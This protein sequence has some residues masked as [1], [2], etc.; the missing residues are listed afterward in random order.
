MTTS[1]DDPVVSSDDMLFIFDDHTL[2][3]GRTSAVV[4]RRRQ[5]LDSGNCTS[6]EGASSIYVTE[7]DPDTSQLIFNESS[8]EGD[9]ETDSDSRST[10]RNGKKQKTMPRQKGKRKIIIPEASGS[11]RSMPSKTSNQQKQRSRMITRGNKDPGIDCDHQIVFTDSEI[12][13]NLK[14]RKNKDCKSGIKGSSLTK[15]RGLSSHKSQKGTS[16]AD[17]LS[18]DEKDEISAQKE[19]VAALGRSTR[20]KANFHD[21]AHFASDR[22]EL[23]VD[24]QQD[25]NKFTKTLSKVGL[26]NAAPSRRGKEREASQAGIKNRVKSVTVKSR[27]NGKHD[28]SIPAQH[29]SPQKRQLVPGMCKKR[30]HDQ[31]SERKLQKPFFEPRITRAMRKL[32]QEENKAAST[33]MKDSQLE[34]TLSDSGGTLHKTVSDYAEIT[35][36]LLLDSSLFSFGDSSDIVDGEKSTDKGQ[37][38]DGEPITIE[39]EYI[40]VLTI[41]LWLMLQSHVSPSIPGPPGLSWANCINIKEMGGI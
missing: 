4:A 31:L 15:S 27:A 28:P 29:V 33:K 21:I 18:Q 11:A 1:R 22:Q 37:I 30:E 5:K 17:H 41:L 38:M 36:D 14:G 2:E 16:S 32:A 24:Q 19:E 40:L 23:E 8:S 10:E 20:L 35:D 6:N 9:T 26:K 3:K 7:Q 34:H 13:S 12:K 39:S 25:D